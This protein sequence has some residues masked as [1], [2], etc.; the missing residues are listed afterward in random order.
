MRPRRALR[1]YEAQ[2]LQDVGGHLRDRG[3]DWEGA[4]TYGRNLLENGYPPLFDLK[5]LAFVTGISPDT[6]RRLLEA[7]GS[8]YDEFRIPKRMGGSRLIVAPQPELKR[9]QQWLQRNVTCVLPMHELAHGFRRARSIVSNARPHAAAES[10]MKMDLQDFFGTVPKSTVFR[11]LRRAGYSQ[12]VAEAM[13]R[14]ATLN[15]FL[16]QGA[17]TSPD[18]ANAAAY[19]LD[20]RLNGLSAKHQLRYTRYADDLTFSGSA[21]REPPVRRAVEFIIRDSGFRP[22]EAKTRVMTGAG[23]NRVTGVV[24]NDGLSWPRARRRWLRQEVHYL[25]AHGVVGH[26]GT[27]GY[28]Q[29]AYKEF[30]YGHV[31]ALRQLHREEADVHLRVLDVVDWPY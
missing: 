1:H 24:V 31:Y 30:I 17:P 2:Y 13:A 21:V 22:N 8:Y 4:V 15:G 20:L 23:Q 27:R 28:D 12:P 29:P 16:P 11:S 10:V 5:H 26:L 14:L 9:V 3:A 7:P 6:I 18:L 19:R 25:G